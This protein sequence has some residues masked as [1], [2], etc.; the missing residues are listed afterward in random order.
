[1][2]TKASL[3][4]I[5]GTAAVT[6]TSIAAAAPA[7]A[8]QRVSL[9]VKGRAHTF[10]LTPLTAGRFGRDSGTFSDCCWS[11]RVILRDGQRIEIENP[12]ATYV[13][14]RGT[15]VVRYRVEWANAGNGYT[16][17]TGAWKIVRGTGAYKGLTGNG[18]SAAAWSGDQFAGVRAEGWVR[19]R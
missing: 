13:G 1:M 11:E 9:T 6:L 8:K 17:G 3:W 19:R 4:V 18:R 2:R 10:V 15:L 12:L 7:A 14:R 5:L 16:V